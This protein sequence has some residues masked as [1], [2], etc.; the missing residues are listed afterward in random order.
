MNTVSGYVSYCR[1][2]FTVSVNWNIACERRVYCVCD[3]RFTAHWH[4][5]YLLSRQ[6]SEI[7]PISVFVSAFHVFN[8]PQSGPL[9]RTD[10]LYL[11]SIPS[12]NIGLNS[13]YGNVVGPIH[14][15]TL[16]IRRINLPIS[17][18]VPFSR[19]F[20]STQ[21]SRLHLIMNKYISPPCHIRPDTLR[22]ERAA[23]IHQRKA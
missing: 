5:R 13:F 1:P 11:Q 9:C 8:P 12:N 4:A 20:T 23:K 6:N 10:V 14:Q 3:P 18:T 7:V 16:F 2:T 19:L 22:K 21:M 15:L 17:Q